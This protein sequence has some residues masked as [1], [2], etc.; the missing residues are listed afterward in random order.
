[1]AITRGLR[2]QLVLTEC[3]GLTTLAEG[4]EEAI[5]VT[6]TWHDMPVGQ[7]HRAEVLYGDVTQSVLLTAQD[8][9]VLARAWLRWR[10]GVEDDR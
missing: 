2:L 1:M 7:N 10:I 5:I 3:D 6:Q 8:L 9:D 4:D